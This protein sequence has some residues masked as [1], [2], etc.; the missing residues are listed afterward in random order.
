[1][2]KILFKQ[3]FCGSVYFFRGLVALAGLKSGAH[4]WYAKSSTCTW[5][6]PSRRNR[7]WL[8]EGSTFNV[9]QPTS[10]SFP[11]LCARYLFLAD[12]TT[13]MLIHLL[14]E[15]SEAVQASAMRRHL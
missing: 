15:H 1:M 11:S 2:V 8:Y 9:F 5:P 6:A 13:F 12:G 7:Q 3:D 10:S 4:S 14:P